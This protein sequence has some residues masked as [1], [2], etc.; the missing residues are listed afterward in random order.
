MTGIKFAAPSN[1]AKHVEFV[2]LPVGAYVINLT[3]DCRERVMELVFTPA[4]WVPI[5]GM[6]A[7]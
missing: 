7:T 1:G 4:L 3:Y 5:T 6:L 2:Y